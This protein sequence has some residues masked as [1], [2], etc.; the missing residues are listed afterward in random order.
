MNNYKEARSLLEVRE[1]KEKCFQEDKGL[2]SKER[3]EKVKAEAERIKSKFGIKLEK[4]S[5]ST[6]LSS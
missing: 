6:A 5:L 4:V 2:S 3:L 1:W